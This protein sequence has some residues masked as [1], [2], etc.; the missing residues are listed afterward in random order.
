MVIPLWA[1]VVSVSILCLQFFSSETSLKSNMF[2]E[3]SCEFRGSILYTHILW[4]TFQGGF[5]DIVKSNKNSSSFTCLN[6]TPYAYVS[7]RSAYIVPNMEVN[8]MATSKT[9]P[10]THHSTWWMFHCSLNTSLIPSC[11]ITKYPPNTPPKFN[12][13]PAKGWLEDYSDSPFGR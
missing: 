8:K 2:Q 10:T 6:T 12:I 3:S 9:S 5:Q 4:G 7:Q 13:A 11:I 1:S